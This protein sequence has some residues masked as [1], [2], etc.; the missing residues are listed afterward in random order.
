MT[1][2]LPPITAPQSRA[3][4]ALVGWSVADLAEASGFAAGEIERFE[5]EADD[6][7]VECPRAIR[8]ALEANGVLFLPE[9]GGEGIGVRLKFPRQTVRRIQTW[10]DEGGTPGE[11][12][13]A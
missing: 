3:G 13:I 7:P 6:L 9:M 5:A 8:A 2:P 11:D 1:Q 12:D 10:E 4:R